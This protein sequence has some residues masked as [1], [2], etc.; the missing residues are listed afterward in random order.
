MSTRKDRSQQVPSTRGPVSSQQARIAR[1][2]RQLRIFLVSL[3]V[4]V[5]AA[6]V[7]VFL[8]QS[9]LAPF[10]KT[11][12]KVDGTPVRMGYFLT[13]MKGSTIDTSDPLSQLV[14]EQFVK[15]MAPKLG[16]KI[17]DSELDQAIR[18]AAAQSSVN[19]TD[20]TTA[21]PLSE[22]AFQE[23][24]KKTLKDSG[25]SNGE[26]RDLV[27]VNMM[28]N[29]LL[30]ALAQQVPT[31]AAQ[32]HLHVILVNTLSEAYAA[33][34][35]LDGGEAFASVA[36]AVSIDSSQAN[37]GDVGWWPYGVSDHDDNIFALVVG[38]ISSPVPADSSDSSGAQYI[39]MVS[40]K[41]DNREIDPNA[42]A[43][44]QSR[45]LINWLQQEMSQ[46]DIWVME[47]DE[48]TQAW[49]NWQLNK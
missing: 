15:I 38:Q 36:S 7:G 16:V 41:A 1:K 12:I 42:Y 28:A 11:I 40:E 14:R 4:V 45:A 30:Y 18:T 29:E 47:F 3:V 34:A 6:L 9:Y 21:P 49:V 37:G 32:V 25:L 5:V 23:W 20:N 44:L 31:S 10:Q 27:R 13:R 35:R 22:S 8:Y 39:F 33:K 46:H 48:Q 17:S 26:Y 19:A 2:N 43:T 24:Y